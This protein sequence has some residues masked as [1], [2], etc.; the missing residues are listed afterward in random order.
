METNGKFN[1]PMALLGVALSLG[2]IYVTFYVAGKAWKK[3]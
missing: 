2:A 3:S 1:L